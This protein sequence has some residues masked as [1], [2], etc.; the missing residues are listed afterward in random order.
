MSKILEP[1]KKRKR[2]IVDSESDEGEV[3]SPVVLHDIDLGKSENDNLCDDFLFEDKNETKTDSMMKKK[4]ESAINVEACE[5]EES[6]RSNSDESS[7]KSSDKS[8][9]EEED[10]SDECEN[11]VVKDDDPL[12]YDTD[13]EE[14]SESENTNERETN[15]TITLSVFH[16]IVIHGEMRKLY[17]IPL[18]YFA[19]SETRFKLFYFILSCKSAE[20]YRKKKV[21][22][23]DSIDE[24]KIKNCYPGVFDKYFEKVK[25]GMSHNHAKHIFRLWKHLLHIKILG[26]YKVIDNSLNEEMTLNEENF[27]SVTK[28]VTMFKVINVEDMISIF[29]F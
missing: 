9:D 7:D 6:D 26:N 13:Y 14:E 28:N 27:V 3:F 20:E 16:L 5:S 18:E 19:K 15:I 8:G 17:K 4:S 11:F 12:I 22:K 24:L 21:I 23:I 1:A 2:V 25:K 10:D 29:V